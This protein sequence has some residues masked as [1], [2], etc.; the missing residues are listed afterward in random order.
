VTEPHWSAGAPR[1]AADPA[2]DPVAERIRWLASHRRGEASRP[3]RLVVYTV[4]PVGAG[5]G[6]HRELAQSVPDRDIELVTLRLPGRERRRD[7]R[8]LTT[9]GECVAD[10]AAR[11]AGH[12]A[13]HR[14]PF[15]VLGDCAMSLLAYELAR[16]LE[17]LPRARPMGMVAVAGRSPQAGYADSRRHL[18][19]TGKLR[20]EVSGSG[21]M[22]REIT[23]DPDVFAMF[24]AAVRADLAVCETY[25]WD[26]RPLV[27]VP[28]VALVPAPLRADPRFTGWLQSTRAGARLVPMADPAGSPAQ[29]TTVLPAAAEVAP[30]LA[31]LRDLAAVPDPRDTVRAQVVAAWTGLLPE[32]QGEDGEDF[33]A[34]GGDSILAVRLRNAV[35]QRTGRGPSLEVIL[36][37]VTLGELVASLDR[38][39]ATHPDGGVDAGR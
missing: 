32:S 8:P 17:P 35:R 37:G 26:R 31:Q 22:P 10:L 11:V 12:V 30:E 13:E 36:R 18:A 27:H 3:V 24:E 20:A 34:V 16:A 29:V 38:S 39:G 9:M 2:P 14:L 7:E 6:V 23:D 4:P 15:A 5:A 25:V 19:S 21:L 1:V 28:V 33:L